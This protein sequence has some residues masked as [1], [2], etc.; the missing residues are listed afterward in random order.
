M[1]L[2]GMVE[3]DAV[4]QVDNLGL[5]P[6]GPMPLEWLKNQLNLFYN[7]FPQIYKNDDRGHSCDKCTQEMIIQGVNILEKQAKDIMDG[8][9]CGK[10]TRNPGE[11]KSCQ[12]DHEFLISNLTI[13]KCWKCRKE[14]GHSNLVS[15]LWSPKRTGLFYEHCVVICQSGDLRFGGTEIILDITG[16]YRDPKI[17]RKDF[18][19]K[20]DDTGSWKYFEP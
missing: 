16:G 19:Q 9:A 10:F 12:I 8:L 1:N 13:P 20:H 15:I 5:F 17:W 2:Y 3:N 18:P 4:N 14:C 11:N 6:R 7:F